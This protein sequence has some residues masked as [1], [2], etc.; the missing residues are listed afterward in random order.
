MSLPD[1]VLKNH[2]SIPDDIAP[3]VLPLPAPPI[4]YLYSHNFFAAY[5]KSI[6]NKVALQ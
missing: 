3:A 6:H 1:S 2:L 5:N 4:K